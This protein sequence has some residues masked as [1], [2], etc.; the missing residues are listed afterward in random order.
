MKFPGQPAAVQIRNT[1]PRDFDSIVRLAERVYPFSIPWQYRQLESH[2]NVFPEG[3]FVA[4]DQNDRVVGMAASL[5]VRWDEYRYGASWHEFTASGMF[6]NHNPA[7]GHT[8]YGAELMIDPHLRSRG[9]GN[10]IDSARFS[11]TESLSLWRIRAGVRLRN[12]FRYA[13]RLTARE[14]V[15]AVVRGGIRDAAL[16]N[17]FRHGFH[18]LD[19]V[20]DFQLLDPES[21]GHALL[22]EWLNPH[23]EGMQNLP[24]H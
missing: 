6:T 2:L 5:I 11:L 1:T 16:A 7:H 24:R 20:D 22:I 19:V 9:I 13:D 3:Q 21:L 15:K 14:Y 8:L 10:Q 17:H 12:Y 18:I 4:V 23:A